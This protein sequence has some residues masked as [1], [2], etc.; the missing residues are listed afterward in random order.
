[1]GSQIRSLLTMCSYLLCFSFIVVNAVNEEKQGP[2][3]S[4]EKGFVFINKTSFIG[5][6]DDDFVCATLDWWPTQKC[7]YGRCSW[8]LASILNLDLENN[9]L[10]N[11]LKAFS[12]LKIRLGGTL[13]DK[14]TYGTED[15]HYP[16]TPFVHN[17]ARMFHFTK[18]CLPMH[19]WDELNI[20]F[21]KAG[22]K[23]IFGLNALYGKS[24][25]FGSATGPWNHTNAESFIRYTVKKNYT[26]HGWELG[27]YIYASFIKNVKAV[28]VS[29]TMRLKLIML[30]LLRVSLSLSKGRSFFTMIIIRNELNG[31][32][33]IG[34]R[35]TAD[36]YASDIST[37]RH[38]IEDVYRGIGP[39]PLVISPGGFFDANWFK[40]FVTKAGKSVDV[41]THHIYNLGPG[42]DEHISK[43]ILDPSYLDGEAKTFNSLKNILKSSGTSATAWVG[44]AGGAYNSG[45]HLV[46]DA[47]VN[48]FWLVNSHKYMSVVLYKC[49]FFNVIIYTQHRYLDQLGM[50]S[51]YDTRAY[52]R[53]TLVGGNYGLLNS[54]TFMPN[55]DYYSALLWHRLMGQRVLAASFSGTKKIRAYA[56]CAKQPLGITILLL[57]LG[58]S[59]VLAEVSKNFTKPPHGHVKFREE[60][61]LTAKNQN[62]HSQVMLLNGQILSVNKDGVIPP[63]KPVHVDPSKPII[64]TPLSVVFAHIPDVI[65]PACT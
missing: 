11:A 45:H 33:G 15:Y 43:K 56:H 50:S 30:I 59:T 27:K 18:G 23:I 52:C 46:S 65:L 41:I 61:H 48:S 36:R 38:M 64:V 37:L 6:I 9:V 55:P 10:L 26:I 17:T 1:M 24:V 8:G 19:R 7:D 2:S 60:Y 42:V 57:N 35:I 12:P 51:T 58:N 3:R 49:F 29:G 22:A 4:T 39:K 40:K 47:F 53:Q 13:Q 34:A 21:K 31:K 54:S 44:E 20:F 14:V 25:K 63:L 28:S 16:C 32:K 5:K 62:L